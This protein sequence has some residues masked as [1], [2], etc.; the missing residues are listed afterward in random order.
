[1][2]VLRY[3]GTQRTTFGDVS[4]YPR[5]ENGQLIRPERP[6]TVRVGELVPQQVFTVPDACLE[7]FIHRRDIEL[8]TD[9]VDALP[10]A[11]TVTEDAKPKAR[12]VKTNPGDEDLAGDTATVDT[13]K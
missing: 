2:A 10:D 3:H 12:R 4:V 7:A 1:M 8:V 6:I 5:D 9:P 13:D 11:P